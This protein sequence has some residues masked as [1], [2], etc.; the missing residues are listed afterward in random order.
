MK[1]LLSASDYTNLTNGLARSARDFCQGLRERGHEVKVLSYG[2]KSSLDYPLT[3]LRIPMLNGYIHAQNF[4][5][6]RPDLHVMRA[7]LQWAD[8]VY[9]EDPLPTNAVLVREAKR[10]QIPIVGSFHVY[11]ENFLA[12]FPALNRSSVSRALYGLFYT[13]VYSFCDCIHAPTQAVKERLERFGYKVPIE[14]FSNGLPHAWIRDVLPSIS[15]GNENP[16][17]VSRRFTLVSTGRYAPEKNHEVLL[18]ALA[19][20]RHAPAIDL[21]LPGRGPLENK[22]RRLASPLS[23]TVHFGFISHEDVQGLLDR[24]DLYVHCATV[25]IEGLAALEAMARGVT[26]LIAQ[27]EESSTWQYAQDERCVFPYDNPVKLARLIDYW[28]DHPSECRDMGMKH[29]ERA[30]ALSMTHSIDAIE[31]LLVRTYRSHTR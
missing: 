18:R 14:A 7:A 22:L 31:S 6:A 24:A 25:E 8:I 12:P 5:I 1:I 23:A 10:A 30:L 29:Y 17:L 21:H 28:L 19:Y 16:S 15:R 27:S 4:R 9:V 26:P 3:E 13:S 2:E 20:S 11:P